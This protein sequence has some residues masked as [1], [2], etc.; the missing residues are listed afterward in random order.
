MRGT[1]PAWRGRRQEAGRKLRGQLGVTAAVLFVAFL[2]TGCWVFYNTNVLNEYVPSDR[3][4]DRQADYE[5]KYRQYLDLPMPRITDVVADVD[6]FPKERR[7]EIRGHYRLVNKHDQP[8]SELHIAIDR[9]VKVDHLDF[10]P[11]DLT[12][13]DEIAGYR[14]YKLKQ[15]LAP[16]AA[17]DFGFALHVAYEGFTNAG[18]GTPV[19][20]N[21]TFFNNK[22]FFPNFGYT[23]T[24]QLDDRNERRKRGLGDVPRMP[25]LEDEAARANNY[26]THDADWVNFDTTVSTSSDQIALAPGYL[27]KE[28]T[29]KG[30]HYFHYKMDVPMLPFWSYL[31]ARYTVK[32]DKWKDVPIEIYYDAKHPY[33]VDRMIDRVKKSLDY[34]TRTSL[35]TSTARCGSWSSRATRFAQSFANTIPFSESI[36]FI[37]D[38][39]DPDAVDMPFYVTAHEVAH[40]WWAHQVIGADLQG[41]TMLSESLAQYSALMVMEK[42]YGREKM[43]KF[44]KYELD[45]YLKNRGGEL[46]EELPLFRVENQPY[47]HYRKGSL[48]FYRLRDEIGEDHL[49]RALSKFVKEKGFQQPPYTTSRELLSYIREETPADRQ[50]FVTDSL[51]EDH[52]L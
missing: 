19:N 14:I 4:F 23:A 33:D 24:A 41:S 8:I 17:M 21:G 42:E 44:L 38:L 32:R 20:E 3:K 29:E 48:T 27:Q 6:I 18:E 34:F 22:Q 16:G 2:G 31:S 15:P 47:I 11:A 12:A 37:M 10:A 46:V 25:K 28:W 39:K 35:R 5:K 13:N 9:K 26:L 51:R 50:Q 49:N 30:R 1:A 45:S 36:G 40:Q 7:V 52:L 43:R